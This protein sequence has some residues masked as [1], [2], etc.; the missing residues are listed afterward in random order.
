MAFL[1][2][3]VAAFTALLL[4]APAP[5]PADAGTATHAHA[6][7]KPNV[8]IL[9]VVRRVQHWSHVAPPS[10]SLSPMPLCSRGARRTSHAHGVERWVV[11]VVVLARWSHPSTSALVALGRHIVYIELLPSV[12]K[13]NTAA[14][15]LRRSS[16]VRATGMTRKPA[17]ARRRARC[18]MTG[19]GAT[20]APTAW[21]Q[22]TCPGLRSS[23]RR[24]RAPPRSR[25]P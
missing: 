1:A 17:R 14:P 9:F 21:R 3:R 12:A 25:R 20:S 15:L 22:R 4:L 10:L 2:H 23:T 8:V 13:P 16:P 5:A 7:S 24:R 6:G 11:P 19:A 18:R